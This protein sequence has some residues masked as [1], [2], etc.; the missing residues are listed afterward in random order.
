MT[1]IV[2]IMTEHY[3]W[4]LTFT[5]FIHIFLSPTMII[6]PD[7]HG[8]TFWK[9]AV[10]G[11]ESEDIVFLGDYL[12]PYSYEG[13]S[14]ADA[15]DNLREIL[16]FKLSHPDNVTLLLGNHDLGYLCP[17]INLCRHDFDRHDEI[18]ALLKESMG[19]FQLCNSRKIAGMT[20]LFSHSFVSN[21]WLETCKQFLHFDYTH[22][23][24]I[25]GILNSMFYNQQEKMYE[26][27]AMVSHHRGGDH[28]FGSMVWSD[29]L[30]VKLPVPFIDGVFNVFG[31]SQVKKPAICSQ[32][33][34]LDC[35]H[36]FV[37]HEDSTF[38]MIE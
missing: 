28:A 4:L 19:S 17:K 27:L 9:E 33:A 37:L 8:R 32:F 14:Y 3:N 15:F 13:I 31:H 12:D 2:F 11:R 34:C 22:P 38:S 35:R 21:Y 5:L 24:E 30:E 23:S 36:A 20:Y 18:S 29:L 10:S 26:L 6:M 1:S 7:I 25:A 16:E